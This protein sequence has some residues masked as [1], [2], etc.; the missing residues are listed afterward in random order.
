[1]NGVRSGIVRLAGAVTTGAWL[2]V[3]SSPV[4][5]RRAALRGLADVGRTPPDDVTSSSAMSVAVAVV[6]VRVGVAGEHHLE[7][8]VVGLAQGAG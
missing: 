1:M 5:V 4:V 2:P 7:A 8:G 3:R 6:G